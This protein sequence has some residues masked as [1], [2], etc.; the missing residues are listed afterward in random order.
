[1]ITYCVTTIDNRFI[2]LFLMMCAKSPGFD[3]TGHG[4]HEN[5]RQK[6]V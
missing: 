2:L 4:V 3:R 1:M 6:V 5:D